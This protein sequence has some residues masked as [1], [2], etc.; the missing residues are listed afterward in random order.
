MTIDRLPPLG[1]PGELIVDRS[2]KN[3]DLLQLL[4]RPHCRNRGQGAG[5]HLGS[6]AP[7]QLGIPT[8]QTNE[9]AVGAGNNHL[10]VVSLRPAGLAGRAIPPPCDRCGNLSAQMGGDRWLEGCAD[11]RL[12]AERRQRQDGS[13]VAGGGRDAERLFEEGVIEL[14][15]PVP[16]RAVEQDRLA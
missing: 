3:T 5:T 12:P 13:P 9:I 4:G 11:L 8:V 2:Q 7:T 16:M 1:I 15:S 10:A 14:R 6:A